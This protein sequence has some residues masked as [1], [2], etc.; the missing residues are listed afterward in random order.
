MK[1]L[2]LILCLGLF[3]AA[4]AQG[5]TSLEINSVDCDP[6]L[7]ITIKSQILKHTSVK[8]TNK[9]AT[10][11]MTIA[12]YWEQSPAG[13]TSFYSSWG[14]AD[15]AVTVDELADEST[16]YADSVTQVA[17]SR[18]LAMKKAA[19]KI[20]MELIRADVFPKK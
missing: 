14:N 3:Q 5:Q 17:K 8:I 12:C 15:L 4:Y 1:T 10:H 2:F 16:V 18:G 7:Q 19:A 13:S 9:G 20:V 6:G 11:R